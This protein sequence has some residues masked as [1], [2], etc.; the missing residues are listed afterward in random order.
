MK[1]NRNW[2]REWD[3]KV[4]E[5]DQAEIQD[6]LDLMEERETVFLAQLAL[7]DAKIEKHQN[8]DILME[9]LREEAVY[10]KS[11]SFKKTPGPTYGRSPADL[12][13]EE[14][15]PHG[16]KSHVPGAKLD[17]GKPLAGMCLGAFSRALQGVVDVGTFGANKY[18]K[19]GWLKVPDGANRY[20]DALYRHLLDLEKTPLD[21]DSGLPTLAHLC[22]NA[23]AWFELV[24]RAQEMETDDPSD[25]LTAD[26]G[27]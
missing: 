20:K 12:I 19:F 5:C 16:S 14:K 21:S 24:L 23:L 6:S 8:T 15:D 18:S 4:M 3:L 11:G 2:E 7:L 17:A 13:S 25:D 1:R 9:A 10:N 26:A 27:C 22:W